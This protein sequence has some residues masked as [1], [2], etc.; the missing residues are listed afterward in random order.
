M[1]GQKGFGLIELLIVVAILGVIAFAIA[2]AANSYF[3]GV[4]PANNITDSAAIFTELKGRHMSSLNV[5][6]LQFVVDYYINHGST[7]WAA[8][9]QNQIIILLLQQQ[10][11]GQ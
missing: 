8:I 5:T 11:E 6:E 7:G 9:Y 4:E 1:R 2:M 3:G 10:E